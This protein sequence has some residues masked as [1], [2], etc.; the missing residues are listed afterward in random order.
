[1]NGIAKADPR[2]SRAVMYYSNMV[3]NGVSYKLEVL[4]DRASNSIWHFMYTKQ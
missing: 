4:Y 1:M 3:K 2:G